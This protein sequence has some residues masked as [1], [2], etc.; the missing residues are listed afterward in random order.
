MPVA[1]VIWLRG[2]ALKHAKTWCPSTLLRTVSL[3]N[4]RSIVSGQMVTQL[5]RDPLAPS[6]LCGEEPRPKV[7]ASSEEKARLNWGHMAP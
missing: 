7:G 3:S 4:G 5:K 6:R 1:V 2:A